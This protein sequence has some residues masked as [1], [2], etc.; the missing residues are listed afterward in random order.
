[1]R[2]YTFVKFSVRFYTFGNL[3]KFTSKQMFNI[4]KRKIVRFGNVPCNSELKMC[5]QNV[6]LSKCPEPP[7]F[8]L[9]KSLQRLGRR[10]GLG[11]QG[12]PIRIEDGLS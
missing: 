5:P 1:M 10:L 2:F 11:V 6:S 8:K 3:G 7:T 12:I 9:K 4:S